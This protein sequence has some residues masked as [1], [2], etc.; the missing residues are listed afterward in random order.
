MAHLRYKGILEFSNK[1]ARNA[2]PWRLRSTVYQKQLGNRLKQHDR[3]LQ[4]RESELRATPNESQQTT[5]R[6]AL[7]LIFGFRS[8]TSDYSPRHQRHRQR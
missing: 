5:P 1:L 4:I 6:R 8:S 3:N 2:V 7:S